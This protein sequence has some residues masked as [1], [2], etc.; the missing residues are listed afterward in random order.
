MDP[1]LLIRI[2]RILFR[3]LLTVLG[4]GV[5]MTGWGLC[6]DPDS[7]EIGVLLMLAGV[8]LPGA[9]WFFHLLKIAEKKLP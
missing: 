2:A 7:A 3:V 5:M 9:E 8:L 4:I 1:L 6:L